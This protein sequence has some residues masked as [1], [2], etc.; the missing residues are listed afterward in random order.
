MMKY[1][2]LT[3]RGIIMQFYVESVAL[4]Y[5]SL[6]GGVIMTDAVLIDKEI[7]AYQSDI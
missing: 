1:T 7:N 3:K 4:L 5:Q 2:L 6:Y